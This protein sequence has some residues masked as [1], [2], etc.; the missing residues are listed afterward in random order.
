MAPYQEEDVVSN[1]LDLISA[2]STWLLVRHQWLINTMRCVLTGENA[3]P[4]EDLSQ[5][6]H[7]IPKNLTLPAHLIDRFT[8][9]KDTL[10][11]TWEETTKA[12]HPM[13]GLT[14][15]EQLNNY[16][17]LAH[18]F[19]LASTEANQKLIHEFALR[20]S[21]TGALTRLSLTSCLDRELIQSNSHLTTSTIAMIDQDNFKSINDRWGHVTGDNVIKETAE[22]IQKNLRP[23]DKL[24]RFGGDEWLIFMPTTSIIE[25]NNIIQRINEIYAEHT[26]MTSNGNTFFTSFSFGIASSINHTRTEQWIAEADSHLYKSKKFL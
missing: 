2:T 8:E 4:L 1:A 21:L 14:I 22:I 15:F 17:A 19:M 20:D 24:F 11:I 12:I 9:I 23:T 3:Q 13:S 18:R 16:Q 6:D 5:F 25:A 10:E 7:I 26:F